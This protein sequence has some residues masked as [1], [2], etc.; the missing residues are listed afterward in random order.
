M[1]LTESQQL[2]IKLTKI[3][4]SYL[5]LHPGNLLTKL[6]Q[7]ISTPSKGTPSPPSPESAYE[8]RKRISQIVD[9]TNKKMVAEIVIL[10]RKRFGS[11][12]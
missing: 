2:Y 4:N 7:Q 3:R 12:R 9:C 10:S 11:T 1:K 5:I 8:I 6:K